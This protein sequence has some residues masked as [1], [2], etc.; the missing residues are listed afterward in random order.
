LRVSLKFL[1]FVFSAYHAFVGALRTSRRLVPA[2]V[3]ST[4]NFASSCPTRL[5][6]AVHIYVKH[7]LRNR[8][9]EIDQ[10]YIPS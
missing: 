2:I 3:E 9:L 7:S 10:A 1:A 5:R 4:P 8:T 6:G